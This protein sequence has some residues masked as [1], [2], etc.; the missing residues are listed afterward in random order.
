MEDAGVGFGQRW[1]GWLGVRHGI[2]FGRVEGDPRWR[3]RAHTVV[4]VGADRVGCACISSLLA[5]PELCVEKAGEEGD[6]CDASHAVAL[7]CGLWVREM[8]DAQAGED[9]EGGVERRDVEAAEGPEERVG[10]EGE[11]ANE[12]EGVGGE[13]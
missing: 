1:N 6:A 9:A 2:K 11:V 7:E 13:L 5:L 12:P 10:G 3:G 8:I 4:D